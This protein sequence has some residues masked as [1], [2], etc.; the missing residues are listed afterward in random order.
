[1]KSD[2]STEEIAIGVTVIEM[3]NLFSFAMPEKAM[4]EKVTCVK[5]ISLNLKG[6]HC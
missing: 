4:Y 3:W 2:L 5:L 1:M 6:N